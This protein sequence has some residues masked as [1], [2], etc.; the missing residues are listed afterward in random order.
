LEGVPWVIFAAEVI[1]AN[2][3]G[4]TV[5][6]G[7]TNRYPR[8]QRIIITP[9]FITINVEAGATKYHC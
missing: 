1:M 7:V 6:Q 8:P 9:L 3:F 5:G 4:H 2:L